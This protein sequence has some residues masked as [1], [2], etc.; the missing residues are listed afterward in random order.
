MRLTKGEQVAM[1]DA[2]DRTSTPEQRRAQLKSL[3]ETTKAALQ[4]VK[5]IELKVKQTQTALLRYAKSLDDILYGEE[6]LTDAQVVKTLIIKSWPISNQQEGMMTRARAFSTD[7]ISFMNE[8]ELV[9]YRLLMHPFIRPSR[10]GRVPPVYRPEVRIWFRDVGPNETGEWYHDHVSHKFSG[11]RYESS[12]ISLADIKLDAFDGDISFEEK[13]CQH[14]MAYIMSR[15]YKY[16]LRPFLAGDEMSCGFRTPVTFGQTV[17]H[18]H[19]P[20]SPNPQYSTVYY[21]DITT[22]WV[23]NSTDAIEGSKV[24]ISTIPWNN[25]RTITK[26]SEVI[27]INPYLKNVWDV[28]ED[29]MTGN[30]HPSNYQ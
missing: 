9:R 24:A 28:M 5:D 14:V 23:V 16:N 4:T 25:V 26:R 17:V 20:Q 7:M 30:D 29:V 19:A 2:E 12:S 13:Q 18:T 3:F 1:L 22:C 6:I 15:V 10:M 8:S 21:A 11:A 27:R